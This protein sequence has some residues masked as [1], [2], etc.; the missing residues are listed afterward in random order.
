MVE[1]RVSFL[2]KCILGISG[3]K[4][5]NRKERYFYARTKEGQNLKGGLK[6]YG[7]ETLKDTMYDREGDTTLFSFGDFSLFELI[8]LFKY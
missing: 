6:N 8:F 2:L 3:R 1:L 5:F 7:V 4:N